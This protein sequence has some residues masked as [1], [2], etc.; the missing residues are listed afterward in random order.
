M[1]GK[2]KISLE[3]VKKI[4]HSLLF[5]L[6]NKA[7]A[8][9]KN[10]E[11][12]KEICK[13]NGVETDIIDL[14]PVMFGDI[15]VSATTSHGVITLNYKLLCDGDFEKDY[16]YLVHEF[17]HYFQQCFGD[18]PTKSADDGDYLHN[19]FEQEGFQHQVEYLANEYGENE[20]EKY[21]DHLLDHHD[22][23]GKEKNNLKEV[24]LEKV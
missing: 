12:M 2:P 20:A 18:G 10:D 9:L 4:P 11:V 1:S 21:V 17:T 15:D 24:L 23:E 5:K 7:K 8:S 22:K 19:E 3:E 14:I 16:S 6:I 13:K